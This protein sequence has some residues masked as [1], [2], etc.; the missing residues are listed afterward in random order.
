[1]DSHADIKPGDYAWRTLYR[2]GGVAPWVIL[3]CFLV[4][5]LVM[6]SGEPFPATSEDWLSLLHRN[7]VL[8]LLYFNVLDI[9]SIPLMGPI[10]LALCIALRKGRE[11]LML[12]AAFLGTL[13]IAVFVTPRAGILTAGI[14]LSDRYTAAATEGLREQILTAGD[15]IF[16]MGQAAPQ[17]TGF[18]F[19]AL[20][21]LILSW[22]M[23][24]SPVF[25]KAAAATGILAAFITA[26]DY[27]LAIFAPAPANALLLVAILAWT[28][29][30]ILISRKLLRLA[31]GGVVT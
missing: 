1:M 26:A 10:L 8:G 5:I 23:L 7:R 21:V 17:T 15:G 31:A 3:G 28:A 18:F 20:A 12:V 19:I 6:A 22:V 14:S 4:Q 25:G 16:A 27:F 9:F 2:I 24:R 13:G 29:W 30:W 11:S